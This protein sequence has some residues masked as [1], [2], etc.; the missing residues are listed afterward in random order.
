MFH[1]QRQ[2]FAFV[3]DR[4]LSLRYRVARLLIGEE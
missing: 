3:I 1:P 2:E 4:D